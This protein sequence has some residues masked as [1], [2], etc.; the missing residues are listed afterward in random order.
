[1]TTTARIFDISRLRIKTDGP[2]VRTL[3][4]FCG[5][6]LKCKFCLNADEMRDWQGQIYNP[7]SLLEKIKLDSI[8]F[9]ASDGGVTFGG[10]EPALYSDFIAEFK[11]LCESGWNLAIETS[12]NVPEKH[13]KT[14]A[15]VIDKWYIDIKDMN[16][17]TYVKY[18]H[19]TNFKVI[20]NLRYLIDHGLS[21]RI[22][23]R[24]PHIKGFNR[25]K[26][27]QKSIGKL[28]EMGITD[29]EEFDYITEEKR[30]PPEEPPIMGEIIDDARPPLMG[31]PVN[32]GRRPFKKFNL[33]L[34]ELYDEINSKEDENKPTE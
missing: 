26:D 12:L 11:G 10:G 34:D 21:E 6:P 31:I 20:K 14:L 25:E 23:V 8:Y 17:A 30:F 22:T 4:A 32:T 33:L 18:T 16:L 15:D 24:V 1:M 5:C 7:E 28:R 3:V 29:I 9:H 13:I 2:G 27:I 19:S